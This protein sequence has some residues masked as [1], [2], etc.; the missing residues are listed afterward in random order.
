M[1]A[2]PHVHVLIAGATTAEHA[3]PADGDSIEP[4]R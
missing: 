2:T 4:A 1:T 3:A